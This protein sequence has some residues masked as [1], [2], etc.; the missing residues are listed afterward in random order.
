[1]PCD[2]GTIEGCALAARDGP[3]GHAE[4]SPRSSPRTGIDRNHA[5]MVVFLDTEFTD[6]DVAPRLLSVGIVADGAGHD[7]FYAEVTDP[8]RLHDASPF[9]LQAVLPQFGKID[10]AACH[11]LDVGTRLWAFF[12]RQVHA[13]APSDSLVVVFGYDLE[14]SLT[15]LAIKD[16]SRTCWKRLEG[17]LRPRNVHRMPGFQA[18]EAAS[19]RYFETQKRAPLTRHHALCDA[20]ALR[21]YY[22][23]ANASP[24]PSS[25]LPPARPAVHDPRD[26]DLARRDS[27]DALPT[28]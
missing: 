18:G 23:A 12:D 27:K 2:I 1:M 21:L 4:E 9:A 11:Y 15:R 17:R 24:E 3:V 5:A 19:D 13:L 28:A 10:D 16:V 22:E 8:D 14:W 6:L 7:D 25:P 20:R 26:F